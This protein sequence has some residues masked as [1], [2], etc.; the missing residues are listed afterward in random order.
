VDSVP[1]HGA[2]QIVEIPSNARVCRSRDEA[3]GPVV[4]YVSPW[5]RGTHR[6]VHGLRWPE[7]GRHLG[8]EHGQ[9]EWRRRLGGLSPSAHEEFTPGVVSVLRGIAPLFPR[10][11][12][13]RTPK[14]QA[15]LNSAESSP[16]PRSRVKSR[17]VVY[18]VW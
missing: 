3:S 13:R 1:A 12:P 2:I 4:I 11:F 8:A 10:L 16:S 14:R 18:D 15:G 9:V 17:E 6:S 5:S 7:H